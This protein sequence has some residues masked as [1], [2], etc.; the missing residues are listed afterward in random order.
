M[1]GWKSHLFIS[2]LLVMTCT[3]A[4]AASITVASKKFTENVVIAEIV[5]QL[6]QSRGI[7]VVH[8][9]ELGGTRVLWDA[10]LQGD[11][12]IYPEYS[13]TLEHELFAGRRIEDR[14]QLQSLLSDQGIAM[15]GPLGFNNTYVLGMLRD[16]AGNMNIGKISDLQKY[17]QLRF[18]FSNEFMSRADGWP[19]LQA[20]YRLR[21]EQVRGRPRS[22]PA[23]TTDRHICARWRRC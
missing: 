18:G 6:L 9:K 14:Q 12:D 19:G 11:I 21:P 16:K 17:P 13:G 2:L 20:R 8:K 15:S 1:N 5:T 10:L 4:G 3:T 22:V 23:T 7:D